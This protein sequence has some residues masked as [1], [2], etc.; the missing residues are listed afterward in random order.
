MSETSQ[1]LSVG[2]A[3]IVVADTYCGPMDSIPQEGE[4]LVIDDILSSVGGCAANVASALAKQDL[5]AAVAGCVGRDNGAKIVVGALEDRG[6]DCSQ[7]RQVDDYSTSQ[8]M[9][10]VVKG[11]DRRFV[12]V[13]GANQD[14]SVDQIDRQWIA[15][16]RCFY[17][18]GLLLMPNF[19]CEPLADLLQYCRTQNVLTVLDVVVPQGLQHFAGL[20]ACLPWVDYFLPNDDEAAQISGKTD[21]VD[22]ALHFRSMG[23]RTT[24][25]TCGSEGALAVRENELWRVPAFPVDAVDLTGCGDAFAAGLITSILRGREGPQTLA[26]ASI[27]GSSCSQAVGCYDGVLTATQ[28]EAFIR[29]NQVRFDHTI[30]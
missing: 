19:L 18:G 25:I 7:I 23:A 29:Q 17:V 14:F 30:I 3:G 28:A 11:Q 10:L 1:A 22:Q 26:Y 13:L 6:V 21:P 27:L 9:I 12:H 24:V 20:E 8:T 5:P 4:V 2:C 16:L 15:G